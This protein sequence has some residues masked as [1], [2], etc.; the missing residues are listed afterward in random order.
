MASHQPPAHLV[1][2]FRHDLQILTGGA[3]ELLGVAVSGG[4][5]SLALL[6]LALAAF[7][8]RVEAATVDHHLRPESA[9]EAAHVQEICGRIGCPHAILDVTV[10]AD[11]SGLQAAARQARYAALHQ[12]A[13]DRAIRDLATAHHVDDQAE[14][15]LMRLRRGAGLAG[16]AG[17]RATRRIDGLLIVRPLLGWTKG[18]LGELVA[19][20]D[21][22]AVM[23][24]SNCDPRFDRYAARRLLSDRPEL[25]PLRLARSA[26]ALAQAEEALEYSVD[27]LFNERVHCAGKEAELVPDGLPAELKRRL[28]VR[29]L[30][31]LAQTQNLRG[32][33]VH[34]LLSQLDKGAIG[35]LVGVRC[36]GGPVWRFELAPPRRHEPNHPSTT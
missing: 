30:Q 13:S 21:L 14:T 16:L 15:L 4:P 32:Q 19:A 34:R 18:E 12:W 25:Q 6:L 33:D 11:A 20:T 7:P 3:P 24:P 31:N 2:R 22:A 17:I 35:T 1:S 5:D 27:R 26:A 36:S 9:A 29:I 28:L 8:Q 10:A 23:D